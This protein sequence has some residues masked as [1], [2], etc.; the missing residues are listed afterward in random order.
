MDVLMDTLKS[1]KGWHDDWFF[2]KGPDTALVGPWVEPNSSQLNPVQ[3]NPS[4]IGQFD[5][6]YAKM[7]TEKWD[8]EDL[9]D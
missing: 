4:R 8:R 6:L 1:N 3:V 7:P 5:S 9:N 2:I